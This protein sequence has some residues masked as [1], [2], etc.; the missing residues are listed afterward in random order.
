M[1]AI[2]YAGIGLFSVATVYGVSDYYSTQKKGTLDKLYKEP[3]EA[4]VTE[5]SAA[6]TYV[7][8]VN[9]TETNKVNT[10]AVSK[11]AKKSRRQ[12]K[13][14]RLEDFSRGR[15]EE[16]V[17]LERV[18][19]ADPV[20]NGSNK[21]AAV[22]VEEVKVVPAVKTVVVKKDR[23]RKISLDDFSRAPLRKPVKVEAKAE[24]V[25]KDL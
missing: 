6:V 4:V 17:V 18:I 23:P 20:K 13:T 5:T 2:I 11:V 7:V 12:K 14:I 25:R 10:V 3:G 1:K 19:W 8:P 22:P 16:A 24:I 21:E 9:V 15:I